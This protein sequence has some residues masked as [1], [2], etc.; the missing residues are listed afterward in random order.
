MCQKFHTYEKLVTKLTF[1]KAI[2]MSVSA[3]NRIHT[4]NRDVWV[5]E[6]RV[7]VVFLCTVQFSFCFLHPDAPCSSPSADTVWNT[8]TPPWKQSKKWDVWF[9]RLWCNME[10]K[11][12][13]KRH[14]LCG[15]HSKYWSSVM[16]WPIFFGLCACFLS[17]AN[18]DWHQSKTEEVNKRET[19]FQMEILR[20]QDG[21]LDQMMND[22]RLANSDLITWLQKKRMPAA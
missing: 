2:C 11:N 6:K 4:L 22:H 17:A 12:K 8:R 1:V 19:D 20:I 5:N 7:H 18:G 13:K 21:W 9:S 3:T 10:T 14:L 16:S 15:I